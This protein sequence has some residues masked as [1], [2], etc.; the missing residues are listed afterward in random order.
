VLQ[1]LAEGMEGP[2]QLLLMLRPQ[3]RLGWLLWLLHL[4][5]LL[6]LL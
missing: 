4:L 1:L 6:L 2:H 5:I 3:H